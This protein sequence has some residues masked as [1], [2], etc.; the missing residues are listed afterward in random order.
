[1]EDLVQ[2]LLIIENKYAYSVHIGTQK[3][4]EDLEVAKSVDVQSEN[5]TYQVPNVLTLL[6]IGCQ[7]VFRLL[8]LGAMFHNLCASIT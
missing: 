2:R 1:L 8:T 3:D 7:S 6:P 5:F 4:L